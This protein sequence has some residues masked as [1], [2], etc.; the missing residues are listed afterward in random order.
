MKK[1]L[2]RAML[3]GAMLVGAVA[4]GAGEPS[5]AVEDTRDPLTPAL[6]GTLTVSVSSS[7]GSV[8]STPAGISCRPTCQ[9]SF[10]LFSTVGL[11][12]NIFSGGS[13]VGWEGCDST[14]GTTCSVN[15]TAART[16]TAIICDTICYSNCFAEL[17]NAKECRAECGCS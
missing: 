13:F 11:Q 5:S 3:F 6:V 16:V 17:H 2:S 14:L 8:T 10:P 1:M 12:A 7:K 15:M 9:A 4:C